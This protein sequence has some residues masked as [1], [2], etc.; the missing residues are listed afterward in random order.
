MNIQDIIYKK[1]SQ[2]PADQ[3][4]QLAI[5]KFSGQKINSNINHLSIYT[6]R[7]R[8]WNLKKD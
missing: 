2:E 5:V 8:K 7:V 1:Y 3:W 4:L 6:I